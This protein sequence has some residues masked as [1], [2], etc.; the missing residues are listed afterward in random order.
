MRIEQF[1]Q[2]LP[3]VLC[4]MICGFPR[5]NTTLNRTHEG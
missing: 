1:P 2:Y 4:M 5:M 3:G